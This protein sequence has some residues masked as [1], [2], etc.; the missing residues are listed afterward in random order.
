MAEDLNIRDNRQA[1]KYSKKEML[2]RVLWGFGQYLFRLSPR[3]CFGWRRFVLRCF[4]ASI[5]R[6]VHVYNSVVI[7]FPWNLT[8]G[9]WS[10]I[11]EH[12]YIYNLGPVSLGEKVTISQRAHLC[13]G[14]HDYRQPDLP[15]LKPPIVI[16]DQVWICADAFVGPGVVVGRGAV[17]GARAVVVK[18]VEP[19]AVMAGNPARFIKKRELG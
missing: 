3:P 2:C 17:V 9:D 19:W 7:Y 18:H 6:E 16:E 14:S 11:G 1:V 12:A 13:A 8:V 5:G 15:L 10:A 4:G